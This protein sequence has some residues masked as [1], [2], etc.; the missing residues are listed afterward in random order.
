ML[1]SWTTSD[2]LNWTQHWWG[3]ARPTDPTLGV[4]EHYGADNFCADATASLRGGCMQ[5]DGRYDGSPMLTWVMPFD[6]ARQ[7]VCACVCAG[8]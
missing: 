8:M 5:G 6:A 2:G 3:G 4:A 7:Q 1:V